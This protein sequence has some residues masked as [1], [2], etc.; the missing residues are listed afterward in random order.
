MRRDSDF[1]PSSSTASAAHFPQRSES[2]SSSSE[3]CSLAEADEIVDRIHD[4]CSQLRTLL[5]GKITNKAGKEGRGES[6]A[7]ERRESKY[8]DDVRPKES[9]KVGEKNTNN[10]KTTSSGISGETDLSRKTDSPSCWKNNQQMDIITGCGGNKASGDRRPRVEGFV[11]GG[12]EKT[13]NDG[14]VVDP[15]EEEEEEEEIVEVEEKEKVKVV[16]EEEEEDEETEFQTCMKE[17]E[18]RKLD[19]Q[20]NISE[21]KIAE[22][23]TDSVVEA[24]T[25]DY[26]AEGLF[27]YRQVANDEWRVASGE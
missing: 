3:A 4:M 8:S 23:T 11:D 2:T 9:A 1:P 24:W 12:Y 25:R 21:V 5:Q 16:E 17:T 18:E 19:Q 15:V 20:S 6:K 7:G 27:D 26:E 10:N 13:E 14:V 22:S